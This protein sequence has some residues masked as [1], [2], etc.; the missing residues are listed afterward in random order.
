MSETV[1]AYAKV[2]VEIEIS[3]SQPWS[4][5]EKMNQV[6]KIAQRDAKSLVIQKMQNAGGVKIV[7]EPIVTA[8]LIPQS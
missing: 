6:F 3:L 7:G 5:E 2:R 4:G 8:V 1:S